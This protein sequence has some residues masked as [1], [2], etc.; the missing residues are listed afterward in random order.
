MNQTRFSPF[1]KKN[2]FDLF[3]WVWSE[4]EMNWLDYFRGL[5]HVLK[6]TAAVLFEIFLADGSDDVGG[7]EEKEST[8]GSYLFFYIHIYIYI[9]YKRRHWDACDGL[10]QL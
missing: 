8:T 1:V 10:V 5:V 7:V 4:V 3:F 6:Q 9:L 2:W